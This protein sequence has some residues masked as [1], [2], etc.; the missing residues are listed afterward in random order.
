L[1]TIRS[2]VVE[3]EGQYVSITASVG[4]TDNV[5]GTVLDF[6]ELFNAAD[7]ALYQAKKNGKN[8]VCIVN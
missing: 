5:K 1:E 3:H 7:T 6:N 4:V 2:I 8:Q